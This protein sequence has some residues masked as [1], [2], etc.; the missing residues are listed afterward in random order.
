MAQ[1]AIILNGEQKLIAPKTSIAALIQDLELDISK[2]A[3][4]KNLEIVAPEGFDDNILSAGDKV[5]IVCFI[6][7]G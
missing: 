6:G 1:I 7:G 5:E 3:I 2:I 4:E